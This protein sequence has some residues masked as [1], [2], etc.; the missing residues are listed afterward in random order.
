EALTANRNVV[1]LAKLAREL[2]ARFAAIADEGAYGALKDALAGSGIDAGGGESAL[3]EAAERPADFV[4][5]AISGS[6]G[7]KPTLAALKRGG[8][9]ALANKECLVCAGG[10]FMRSAAAANA[11]I[12]PVDS[13]HNAVF[14]ALSAGRR[15]DVSRIILTA[16][17]GPFRTWSLDAMN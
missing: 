16:S 7:L 13:E 3:I 15:E 2:K 8:I 12:L 6:V 1:A 9:I 5:A 10:L 17:G 14:Q 11:R 4:M